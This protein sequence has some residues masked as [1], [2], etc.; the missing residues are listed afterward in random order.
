MRPALSGPELVDQI[1]RLRP[2]VKVLFMS[3]Y[4]LPP[5]LSAPFLQKPFT[6]HSLVRELRTV[7]ESTT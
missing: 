1:R 3:G 6:I 7:L 2:A 4:A 5:S